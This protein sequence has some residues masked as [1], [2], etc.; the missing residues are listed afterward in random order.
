MIVQIFSCMHTWNRYRCQEF[1]KKHYIVV[2]K[3]AGAWE[4]RCGANLPDHQ[5]SVFAGKFHIL[6][7]YLKASNGVD[8]GDR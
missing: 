6:F 4:C 8:D 1:A 3:K 7:V 5:L 2:I